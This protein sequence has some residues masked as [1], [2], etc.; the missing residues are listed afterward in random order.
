MLGIA[1]IRNIRISRIIQTPIEEQDIEIVERKGR[2]HP[3]YIADAV[4]E[5]V[6]RALCLYYLKTFN[7]ILHHNVDKSLVVGGRASPRFGGGDVEEPIT[8]IVAGR[9]VTQV[10]EDGQIKAVPI[11]PIALGAMKEFL[12]RNFRFLDIDR[13]VVCN[14]MIKQGSVDLME[15]FNASQEMPLSNDTSFG[16]G[17]APLSETERIVYETETYLNSLNV[18]KELPSIGEDVKVMGLRNMN[19]ID[20]TIAVPQIS[21]LTPD[22][23]HYLSIKSE[24]QNRIYDLAMRLTKREVYVHVN[25]ADNPSKGIVYLTVTGTSCEN[26]DDG[27]TGRGNRVYGLI[28]PCRPMSLEAAAGKNPVN[29]VGKIYNILAG[30]IAQKIFREVKGIKEVYVKL[31]SQIGKPIDQPMITDVQLLLDNVALNVIEGDVKSIV[32]EEIAK[33][34]NITDDVIVNRVIIF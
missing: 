10:I 11:G 28:T 5:E 31:L 27:N 29:H 25:T 33:V 32:D 21:S 18:K 9:A 8:I 15:N 19:R 3:D 24:I 13:H 16:I 6:S 30:N 12:R 14:Y 22:L 4:S 20:L 26:G 23:D 1:M 2:G 34:R 17:Y 7:T